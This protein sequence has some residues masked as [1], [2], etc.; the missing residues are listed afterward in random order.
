VLLSRG[1]SALQRVSSMGLSLTAAQVALAF[2][3]GMR[4]VARVGAQ[5]KNIP[6]RLRAFLV[7]ASHP[8]ALEEKARA[9]LKHLQRLD[10][11]L[12]AVQASAIFKQVVGVVEDRACDR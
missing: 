4:T 3:A 10:I 6:S 7:I 2:G 5:W 11:K 9:S 1:I 8:S 12:L